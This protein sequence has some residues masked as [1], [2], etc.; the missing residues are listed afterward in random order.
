MALLVLTCETGSEVG[1]LR[2]GEGIFVAFFPE[3]RVFLAFFEI[4]FPRA[5]F[6]F[7]AGKTGGQVWEKGLA[8]RPSAADKAKPGLTFDD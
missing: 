8:T 4:F 5:G 6:F 7:R 2:P 1:V 3:N